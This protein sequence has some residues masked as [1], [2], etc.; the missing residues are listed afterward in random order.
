M[1]LDSPTEVIKGLLIPEENMYSQLEG[2]KKDETAVPSNFH[3]P[4]IKPLSGFITFPLG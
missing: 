1:A 2:L 4:T 3:P